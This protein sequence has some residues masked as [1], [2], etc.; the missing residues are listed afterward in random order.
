MG[1][2]QLEIW[3]SSLGISI[4][5]QGRCVYDLSCKTFTGVI[6]FDYGRQDTPSHAYAYGAVGYY[7]GDC[8]GDNHGSAF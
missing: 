4:H 1:T 7:N 3:I 6:G 2:G 8:M 5:V